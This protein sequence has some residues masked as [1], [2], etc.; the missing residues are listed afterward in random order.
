MYGSHFSIFILIRGDALT[1][2]LAPL[3]KKKSSELTL[4]E[5]REKMSESMVNDCFHGNGE[6]SL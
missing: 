1:R 3:E 5:R 2:G 6:C 4:S